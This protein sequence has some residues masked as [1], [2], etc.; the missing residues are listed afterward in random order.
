VP[1]DGVT[2][3]LVRWS[4]GNQ[5]ALDELLPIVYGELRRV[6]R[7]YLARERPG[8]TLEPTALV[9]E[10]FLRLVDQR[11]VS[12]QNRAHF[13]GLA[14]RMMRRILVNHALSKDAAKRGG[15]AENI[16]FDEQLHG[17]A[18]PSDIIALDDAL[19]ALAVLDE[20]QTQIVE[21]RFF[22]GLSVEE[23]AE[24]VGVSPATVK[25]EWAAAKLFLLRE[26]NR[27]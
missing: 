21:L 8:H 17:S 27:Q 12:W 7:R 26:I 10:A 15:R 25:R 23:T 18:T 14:A 3:L 16:T 13:F 4:G 6:A 5:A 2:Q 24:V 1:A 20:R 22:G 19:K 9:H 11:S